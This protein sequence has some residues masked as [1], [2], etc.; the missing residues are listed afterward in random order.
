M[1]DGF[2]RL[3]H[4]AVIGGHHQNHQI[5]DLGAA[6]AHRG[7]GG[8]ARRVQ[9]GDL[10]AGFQ[11]HLIGADMLG[12]AAGFAGHDIG[13]AQGVEQRGLAVIDMAHDGDDRRTRDQRA[14]G[15]GGAGQAFQHVAFRDALDDMAI[16]GG[17]QFGGVGVDDVV[18]RRH[19]AVL[20]QHLDDVH[21][22]ARH[23]VGEFGNGDG[24]GNGDVARTGGAGRDCG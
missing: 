11:L 5:G 16:F 24:F 18:G 17:D 10:L 13:L 3:R 21:D 12:D 8:M 4:D 9:E 23:A 20:H 15:I 22:P 14:F 1:G 7:E 6:R 19:H 2:H